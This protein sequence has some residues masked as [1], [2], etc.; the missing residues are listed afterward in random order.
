MLAEKGFSYDRIPDKYLDDSRF[1]NKIVKVINDMTS[2]MHDAI[3]NMLIDYP[4]Y[5]IYA[6]MPPDDVLDEYYP[7]DSV[8]AYKI[9]FSYLN[10]Y[11][12]QN[13]VNLH[14]VKAIK[15]EY[16]SCHRCK[17]DG[18]VRINVD[19]SSKDTSVTNYDVRCSRCGQKTPISK[20]FLIIARNEI[21][22]KM[23]GW[24][25]NI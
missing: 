24:K 11:C 4:V 17:N 13:Y 16:F 5:H 10:R 19:T 23:Y 14:S 2:I 1:A 18:V 20:N 15:Y 21:Y 8:I 3:H 22:K 6:C 9:L 7:Y 12:I 25:S